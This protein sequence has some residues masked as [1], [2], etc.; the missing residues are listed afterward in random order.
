MPPSTP[1]SAERSLADLVLAIA[2]THVMHRES[3]FAASGAFPDP[4]AAAK[5][6]AAESMAGIGIALAEVAAAFGVASWEEIAAIMQP[7]FEE[8]R[9]MIAEHAQLLNVMAP[10]RTGPDS[11]NWVM[12]RA[13]MDERDAAIEES[14]PHPSTARVAAVC[15]DPTP[16]ECPVCSECGLHNVRSVHIDQ[17]RRCTG[18]QM[19]P[20]LHLWTAS[21]ARPVDGGLVQTMERCSKCEKERP[22]LSAP[23]APAPEAAP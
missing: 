12:R 11:A 2:R 7:H 21:E 14:E 18:H 3:A 9:R 20:S 17:D 22:V 23:L 15:E 1:T 16:G 10:T 19:V 13:E 8:A 4:Q 5:Q 6:A